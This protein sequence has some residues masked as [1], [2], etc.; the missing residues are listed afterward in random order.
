V[1]TAADWLRGSKEIQGNILAKFP[2]QHQCFLMLRF[3]DTGNAKA[4]LG[5]LGPQLTPTGLMSGM[6]ARG[7]ITV[8]ESAV[9]SAAADS[10]GLA[11]SFTYRGLQALRPDNASQ[12]E[13]FASFR[14]GPASRAAGLRDLGSS[15][16][17]HWLFGRADQAI[18]ALVTIAA[19]E[20]K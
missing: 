14:H 11:V 13:S 18:D 3:S 19:S 16:P 15:D 12:L 17:R 7:G 9:L 5:Q 2:D 1:D 6:R 20:A 4:W 8:H 10:L